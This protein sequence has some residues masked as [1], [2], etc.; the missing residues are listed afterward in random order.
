[1]PKG[2]NN[3]VPTEA[4]VKAAIRR[5]A[6]AIAEIEGS[7]NEVRDL[8]DQ[9]NTA[10]NEMTS[11]IAALLNGPPSMAVQAPMGQNLGPFARGRN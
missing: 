1:M 4:Q 11:R 7:L 6:A 3:G 10:R 8:A 5:G 9:L 2:K